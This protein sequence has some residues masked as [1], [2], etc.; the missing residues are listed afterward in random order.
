MTGRY[1]Q[2]CTW[3][4]DA[5]LSPA[6]REQR[7]DNPKQRW[8]WGIAAEELTLAAL[9]RQAGYRT[10]LVG[11]WHLG[12]DEAFHPMNRGFEEFRGFV[13]GAVDHHTHIATHGL[14]AL[15]WWHDRR[16][17]NQQGY[18][19]DLLT[20][21]A[22]EFIDRNAGTTFFLCL[23]HAAPHAPLQGRDPSRTAPQPA[24][25]REMIESLDDSVAVV[26]AKL[27]EH[28]LTENTLVV[29]CS[30]NGP[31]P[32][33]RQAAEGPWKL[34]GEHDAPTMLVNLT[35]DLGEKRDRLAQEPERAERLMSHHR[36]WTAA[37]GVR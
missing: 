16:I 6:Y 35:D 12:Y 31:Q 32:P 28:G 36:E 4:D 13:G 25:Y 11:K 22:T 3:V 21:H 14:H 24:V 30:D 27:D 8:A 29:F 15:D 18:S 10:S 19:T 7:R 34:L 20:R 33:R 2:R 17:E 1:Q 26:M 9:L 5:E 37:V 23:A